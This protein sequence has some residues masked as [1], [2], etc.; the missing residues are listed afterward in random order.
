MGTHQPQYV[1]ALNQHYRMTEDGDELVFDDG[2]RY[3]VREAM[4]LAKGGAK[5]EEIRAV[6][7]VKKIF[8]GVLE[9][10][11]FGL[12]QSAVPPVHETAPVQ[13]VRT[14]ASKRGKGAR[15]GKN[16]VQDKVRAEAEQLSFL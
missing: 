10:F 8:R 15:K 6:H 2:V 1:R 5:D 3:T 13:A 9:E 14:M 4:I 11:P 12:V 7:A 16:D